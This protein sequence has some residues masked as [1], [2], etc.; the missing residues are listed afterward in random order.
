[1]ALNKRRSPA[2]KGMCIVYFL[3]LRS[4]GLYSGASEDMSSGS[5]IMDPVRLAAPATSIRRFQS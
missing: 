2:S 3:R 1:M 4:G 5:T